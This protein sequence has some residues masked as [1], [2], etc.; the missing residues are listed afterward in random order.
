MSTLLRINAS[1]QTTQSDSSALGDYFEN[2][3]LVSNPSGKVIKRDLS[4]QPIP[5]ITEKTISAMY[6]SELT[7]EQQQELALSDELIAEIE[8]VDTVVVSCPMYNFG[9]PSPLKAYFDHV[10]RV[11][12]TFNY[13]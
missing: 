1:A 2:E 6:S 4:K 3:W 7:E 10:A 12:K 13:T 8:L 5:H 9:I 11:G